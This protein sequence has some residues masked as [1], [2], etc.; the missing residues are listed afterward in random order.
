MRRPPFA[1]Q[2]R[3]IVTLEL[4]LADCTSNGLLSPTRCRRRYG[5][6]LRVAANRDPWL[7]YDTGQIPVGML[8]IAL[9]TGDYTTKEKSAKSLTWRT[10]YR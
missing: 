2:Q 10:L 4:I 1:A 5:A 9:P 7:E 3:S 6:R 8:P